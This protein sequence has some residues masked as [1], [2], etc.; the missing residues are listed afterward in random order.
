M[1][2]LD[3]VYGSKQKANVV[4]WLQTSEGKALAPGIVN[5]TGSSKL[6]PAPSSGVI[7][8]NDAYNIGTPKK[9]HP[10][11]FTSIS[12]AD[13]RDM[14][15][16]MYKK[17]P[18]SYEQKGAIKDYMDSSDDYNNPLRG[19]KNMTAWS[20][21]NITLLQSAMRPV[22]KSFTTWRGTDGLGSAINSSTIKSL[23]DLKKFE[24]AVVGDPAFLSTSILEQ[25][26]FSGKK[27]KLVINVPEGT[28]ATYAYASG[29][30]VF[31][32]EQEMLLAAGLQFKIDRVAQPGGSYV[33]SPY[34]IYMTVI[35]KVK[36]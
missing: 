11:V 13:A 27:F 18:L 30:G 15:E 26:S 12:K 10:S 5:G 3:Q 17:V 34:Y 33:G 24:G 19:N 6:F 25:G 23:D 32:N 22:T 1:N 21:K 20:Q 35:P 9:V 14:H 7:G 16:E 4:A 29:G 28:P 31:E 36:K 8:M 2:V